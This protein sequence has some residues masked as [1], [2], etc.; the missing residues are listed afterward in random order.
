MSHLPHMLLWTY[1]GACAFKEDMAPT[2]VRC[3][4]A[5]AHSHLQTS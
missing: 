4:L 5:L 1:V 2:G 3:L